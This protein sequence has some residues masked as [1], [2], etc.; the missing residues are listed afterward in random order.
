MQT[1]FNHANQP[2]EKSTTSNPTVHR[3]SCLFQVLV[4]TATDIRETEQQ[5][6]ELLLVPFNNGSISIATDDIHIRRMC[7]SEWASIFRLVFP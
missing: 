5:I 7:E 6:K 1:N 2:L 3:V 4:T